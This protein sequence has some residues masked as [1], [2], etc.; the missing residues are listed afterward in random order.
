MSFSLLLKSHLIFM[1]VSFVIFTMSFFVGLIYLV[2]DFRL[3][4][5][6][7]PIRWLPSLSALNWV[8]YRVLIFGFI[9]LSAGILMGAFLS[10][11]ILGRFFTDDPRQIVS[12]V[13]WSLY[14]FF[15]NAR[16]QIGWKGRRG[17]ILS[18]LGFLGIVLAFLAISH[19]V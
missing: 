19:R 1:T 7:L 3:K 10:K 11:K 9:L 12:L 13:V 18:A 16:L 8:H 5:R 17:I 15:L 6:K 14:A 2:E 4:R